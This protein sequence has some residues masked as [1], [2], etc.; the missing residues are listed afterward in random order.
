MRLQESTVRDVYG[1]SEKYTQIWHANMHRTPF[2]WHWSQFPHETQVNLAQL[3]KTYFAGK[4]MVDLAKPLTAE[5]KYDYASLSISIFSDFW[6]TIVFLLLL[7]TGGVEQTK[8]RRL[9]RKHLGIYKQ[10]ATAFNEILALG[11]NAD[12]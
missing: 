12:A 5:E 10:Y 9:A 2:N 11:Q 1:E 4:T 6:S 8:N 7:T 3:L